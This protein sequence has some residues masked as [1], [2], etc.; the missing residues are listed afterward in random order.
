LQLGGA[1]SARSAEALRVEAA[2]SAED[3]DADAACVAAISRAA[4]QLG[5]VEVASMGPEAA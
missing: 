2:G 3:E 1:R 5:F 4:M